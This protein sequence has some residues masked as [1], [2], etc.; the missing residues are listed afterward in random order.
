VNIAEL[1]LNSVSGDEQE[2]AK[3]MILASQTGLLAKVDSI[4]KEVLW[5]TDLLLLDRDKIRK[6]F[7]KRFST[8]ILKLEK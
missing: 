7:V 2:K 1:I 4:L 5:E 3:E 6:A 8:E